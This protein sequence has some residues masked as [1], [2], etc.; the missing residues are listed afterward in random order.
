M[1]VVFGARPVKNLYSSTN[2]SAEVTTWVWDWSL[3]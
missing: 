1:W 2:V 3:K